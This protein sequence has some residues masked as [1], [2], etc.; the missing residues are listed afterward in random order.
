MFDNPFTPIFGGKPNFFFG[1]KSI[2]ARF[3]AAMLDKGSEDRALLITGNRGCGKTALLEQLSQR[4][5]ASG[6]KTID[7]NSESTVST[8]IRSLVRHSEATQIIEPEIEVSVLDPGGKLHAGAISRTTRYDAADFEVLFV[9][10]CEKEKRGVFVSI[11]EI[12]KIAREDMALICGAFQMASRKGYDVMIALAGLPYSHD[13][14]VHY[15]GCTYMRRSTHV[16]L[17]LFTPEEAREAFETALSSVR[18]LT[19]DHDALSLL[20]EKSLGHPYVIQLLG[21]YL[22]ARINETTAANRYKITTD[23]VKASAPLALVAYERRALAPIVDAL[24]KGETDYLCAMADSV[25]EAHVARSSGIAERLG[26]TAKQTSRIRDKMLREG[27]VISVG[28]GEL[29]FNIPYLR[30]Y[31]KKGRDTQ[32]NVALVQQW[33]L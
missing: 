26:K 30:E 19:L 1:R 24:T 12:Q 22:I 15:E 28:H 5:K 18:G 11:D 32:S 7:V 10:A 31:V 3:G 27:I 25:D 4:A 23:D 16:E 29:M 14:L 6:R 21:Y 9:E 8:I 13:A 2:L 17:G 33:R 20:V